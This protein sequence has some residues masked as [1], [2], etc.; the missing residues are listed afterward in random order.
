M[1]V[2]SFGRSPFSFLADECKQPPSIS[3]KGILVCLCPLQ[4]QGNTVAIALSK[5]KRTDYLGRRRATQADATID[6]LR[7]LN[8][9]QVNPR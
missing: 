4:I 7:A 6:A 8:I 5:I 9:R 2:A 1:G 3:V